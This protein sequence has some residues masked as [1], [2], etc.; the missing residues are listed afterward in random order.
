MWQ[1]FVPVVLCA[2]EGDGVLM[3][4]V[5]IV[6]LVL[7][8]KRARPPTPHV[9]GPVYGPEPYA[10][11]RVSVT[12]GDETSAGEK[13]SDENTERVPNPRKMSTDLSETTETET[14]RIPQSH[15]VGFHWRPS[16]ESRARLLARQHK[17]MKQY[18]L[19]QYE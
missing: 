14:E 7:M 4:I 8:Q 2:C 12:E 17:E 10:S 15:I 18:T 3:A 19:H 9:Y 11:A 1:L 13:T 6:T 5:G 16:S